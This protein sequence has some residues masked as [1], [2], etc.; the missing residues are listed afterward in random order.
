MSFKS[1]DKSIEIN[2]TPSKIW[3]VLFT[4]ET[5]RIWSS[6]FS[7]GS[8]FETDWKEGSKV[9]FTDP[10]KS[11]LVGEIQT[12]IPN[13]KMEI[14]YRGQLINGTED[15]SSDEV[16]ENIKGTHESYTLEEKNGTT[17]LIIHG[18]MG[19]AWYDQMDK[20]WDRALLK[21]KELAE[22]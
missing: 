13:Q 12:N 14:V 3:S 21:I 8:F 15:L 9:I 5:Y 17:N 4:D 2:S 6:V 1:I 10:S 7:D 11:G 22:N 20:S 18:E 16:L 19:E